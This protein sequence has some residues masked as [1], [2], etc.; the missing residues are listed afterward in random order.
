MSENQEDFQAFIHPIYLYLNQTTV[1]D[2]IA[3]SYVTDDV[4]SSGMHAR[5]VVGGFFI[6]LLSDPSVWHKWSSQDRFKLG[7][8]APLPVPP[9]IREVVPSGWRQPVQWRY[10]TSAPPDGWQ[11]PAF[12]DQSWPIGSA[13]FGSE[14]TPGL[15]PRTIWTSDDIWIRRTVT[16]PKDT[17]G[18]QL[19]I[20]HDEDIEVY[21]DGVLAGKAPSYENEYKTIDILPA[22]RALLKPGATIVLAAHCHQTTGGQGIDVGF[23]KVVPGRR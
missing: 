12:S 22:A 23:A 18:L 17:T 1:R 3:D 7:T 5:P 16:L 8:Y 21:V 13:P 10:T 11:I 4:N 19:L 14:G 2:P 9:E 20:Y 15:A 6:K